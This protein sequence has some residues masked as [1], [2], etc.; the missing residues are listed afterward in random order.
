MSEAK[1]AINEYRCPLCGWKAIT[2]TLE[3][4]VTPMFIRCEGKRCDRNTLPAA[5]SMMYRV[6]Q[7]QQPTHEWY[8]PDAK[9]LEGS[10]DG[11]REHV[12]QGGLMLRKL[13]PE[14]N[15]A[16]VLTQEQVNMICDVVRQQLELALRIGQ[17]VSTTIGIGTREGPKG[18][19]PDGSWHIAVVGVRSI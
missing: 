9:E 11:V 6:N 10:T 4:G 2:K 3:D 13:T 16:K 1:N 7:A 19:E 17:P 5:A 15:S 18:P 12:S 14:G 8:R